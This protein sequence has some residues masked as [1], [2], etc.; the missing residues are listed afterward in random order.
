MEKDLCQSEGLPF[1]FVIQKIENDDY[2]W[3]DGDANEVSINRCD[4]PA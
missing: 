1:E 3:D 4:H 2:D